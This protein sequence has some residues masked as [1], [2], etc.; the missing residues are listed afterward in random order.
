MVTQVMAKSIL[1]PA[2]RTSPEIIFDFLDIKQ[3]AVMEFDPISR[4]V[5]DTGDVVQTFREDG[6]AVRQD[7]TRRTVSFPIKTMQVVDA[8]RAIQCERAMR[9]SSSSPEGPPDIPRST[10]TRLAARGR[11]RGP[12][13]RWTARKSVIRRGS[14][15]ASTSRAAVAEDSLVGPSSPPVDRT[16]IFPVDPPL[17]CVVC[18]EADCLGARADGDEVAVGDYVPCDVPEVAPATAPVIDL[19]GEDPMDEAT[20]EDPSE[21]SGSYL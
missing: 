20:E 13:V 1:I 6:V 19:T 2:M 15:G 7:V 4:R 21:D 18:G 8:W 14:A 9:A 3:P 10:A 5:V 16:P 17:V 11:G 12:R